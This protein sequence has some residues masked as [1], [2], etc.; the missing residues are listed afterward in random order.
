MSEETTTSEVPKKD[1]EETEEKEKSANTAFPELKDAEV[2]ITV[3]PVSDVVPTTVKKDELTPPRKLKAAVLRA[4]DRKSPYKKRDELSQF[5]KLS[6]VNEICRRRGCACTKTSVA[7]KRREASE[8]YA[9]L[10]TQDDQY[11][12]EAIQEARIRLHNHQKDQREVIRAARLKI[13]RHA[14]TGAWVTQPAP[15]LNQ[16]T[17][18]SI[19]S[20]NQ[21]APTPLSSDNQLF[22]NTATKDLPTFGSL[23]A[24]ASS[25]PPESEEG[26]A[27][28]DAD[29]SGASF[30]SLRGATAAM[31]PA[32]LPVA[33]TLNLDGLSHSL[34]QVS[35]TGTCTL[36]SHSRGLCSCSCALQARLTPYDLTVDELACYL[37]DFVYIPRKMSSM[38]EMMYI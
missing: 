27:G 29:L 17:S 18:T 32:T 26:A 1:E 8:N 2:K 37:E 16:P 33:D 11:S 6:L 7:G 9:R 5:E 13:H 12:D 30:Q 4:C 20:N 38:A 28:K 10:C 35:A 14:T 3:T 34:T 19:T 25:K 24:A 22:K 15:A 31:S 21:L 36:H 23:A